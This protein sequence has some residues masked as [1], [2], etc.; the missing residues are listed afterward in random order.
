ML[1]RFDIVA[2]DPRGTGR[3]EPF[4]DCIDDYDA[5]FAGYDATPDTEEEREEVID[6][7]VEFADLCASKNADIIQSIGTNNSARDIDAIRRSLGEEQISWFGFSYGSELGATWATLFPDT[8]RAAV[9]DGATDPAS[10]LLQGGLQQ[11]AGFEQTLNTYLDEC[12]ADAGCDF[13]N[14]GDAEGAFD[15]LM[16]K[17]DQKPVPSV[18]GRPRVDR[19]VALQAVAEAMYSQSSWDALSAALADAR[20]GDGAGLLELFDA[21]Y[22]RDP[23]AGT[24]DNSLEAFQ[25]IVCMDEPERLTIEE[26][27]ANSPLFTEVAPRFNPEGSIGYFCTFFPPSTDPR[28]EITA[29]GAGPIVVCGATGDAATP[30]TSSRNMARA[31]EDGRLIVIDAQQHTCYGADR[32]GD[33][34]IESY[35]LELEVPPEV[36]LCPGVPDDIFEQEAEEDPVDEVI[37]PTTQG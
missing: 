36:T 1:D 11:S 35:L 24:W 29:A 13:H 10:D 14:E 32:C 33:E 27:D 19:G 16:L 3:S 5:F 23:V 37:P 2:W 26:E 25:S 7:A 28:I 9:L 20:E 8:V 15:S 6:V 34:L 31:L 18:D 30:V 12:S 22:Q 21:Y 17:L 4:I